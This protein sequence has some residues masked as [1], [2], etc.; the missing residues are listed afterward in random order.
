MGSEQLV[1]SC[2]SMAGFGNIHRILGQSSLPNQCHALGTFPAP[3]SLPHRA[4]QPMQHPDP[5]GAAAHQP[6]LQEGLRGQPQPG[7][8]P[9]MGST[10]VASRA[11]QPEGK[12]RVSPLTL[13][14]FFPPRLLKYLCQK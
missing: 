6:Q 11:L 5:G 8:L 3:Q 9:F 4:L 7:H 13:F 2:R 1:T 12:L 10:E 14:H